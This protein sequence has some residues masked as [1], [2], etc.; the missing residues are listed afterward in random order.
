MEA[1]ELPVATSLI[2]LMQS[3]TELGVIDVL[4]DFGRHFEHAEAGRVVATSAS[5]AIRGR[6]Q[7]A[8]EAAVQGGADEPT[9]AA[10]DSTLRGELNGRGRK[11]IVRQPPARCLGKR[12]GEGITAVLVE[13]L[14]MGD[15]GIEIKGRELVVGKR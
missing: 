6:T 3:A 15:K 9:E 10:V 4:I 5:G 7:G 11:C 2:T 13:G 1:G 12:G 8:G 14:G